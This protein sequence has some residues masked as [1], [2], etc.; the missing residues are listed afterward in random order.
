MGPPISGPIFP[1]YY[2]RSKGTS[3][4]VR[5]LK[6]N[7]AC[8]FRKASAA[9]HNILQLSEHERKE[10]MPCKFPETV[11]K[12]PKFLN[13]WRTKCIGARV[14]LRKFFCTQNNPPSKSCDPFH[15][16]RQSGYLGVI[17]KEPMG[18]LL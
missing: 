3:G 4:T 14:W 8:L 10:L 15:A 17:Y 18:T 12:L 13:T 16:P 11:C 1:Y 2:K 7:L 9:K 6:V 5:C